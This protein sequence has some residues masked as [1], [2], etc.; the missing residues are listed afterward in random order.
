MFAT[1]MRGPIWPARLSYLAAGLFTA[2]STGTNLIYGWSKGADTASSLVWAA[3]SLAVSVVF[4]L[5]WPA[6]IVSLDRRQWA[7]AVM[8][9]IALIVTG[10]LLD[11]RGTWFCQW[12]AR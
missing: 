2:A 5:S 8:V 3:V 10:S 11:R 12:R 4:A 7:R 6:F 1:S 9:L